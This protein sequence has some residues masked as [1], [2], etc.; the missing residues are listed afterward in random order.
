MITIVDGISKN[1]KPIAIKIDGIY[2]LLQGNINSDEKDYIVLT[3]INKFVLKKCKIEEPIKSNN[4]GAMTFQQKW[5]AENSRAN[6]REN[7]YY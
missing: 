6:N 5:N 7:N 3:I 4:N 1:K 2:H